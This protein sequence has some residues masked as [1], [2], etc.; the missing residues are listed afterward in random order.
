[1]ENEFLC[2]LGTDKAN[3]NTDLSLYSCCAPLSLTFN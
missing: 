2:A 3:T 1:M